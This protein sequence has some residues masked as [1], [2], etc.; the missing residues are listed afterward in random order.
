MLDH[1]DPSASA[2]AAIAIGLLPLPMSPSS[3]VPVPDDG[4]NRPVAMSDNDL[5]HPM[6]TAAGGAGG[7]NAGFG[8]AADPSERLAAQRAEMAK[9]R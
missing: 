2:A 6:A 4:I 3:P 8:G 1:T 9:Y 5:M 7:W